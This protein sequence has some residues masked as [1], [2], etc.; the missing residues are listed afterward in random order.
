[1]VLVSAIQQHESALSIHVSFLTKQGQTLGSKPNTRK[2]ITI[3]YN[4]AIL[5]CT[6]LGALPTIC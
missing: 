6:Y 3:R 2:S 1:M 4:F 5:H